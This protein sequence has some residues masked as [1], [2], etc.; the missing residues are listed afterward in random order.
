MKN[1]KNRGRYNGDAG[2]ERNSKIPKRGGSPYW[3]VPFQRLVREIV[4]KRREGMKLQSS[5]VLALQEAGEAFLVGLLKQANM[6][7]IH[8]KQVTIMPRDIQLVYRIWGGFLS[9][10]QGMKLI[11]D[12][13]MLIS[14]DHTG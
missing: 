2:P 7:A 3:R 14:E 9:R 5:V 11:K 10:S 12:K 13:N 4:Q 1:W 6:C 8:A